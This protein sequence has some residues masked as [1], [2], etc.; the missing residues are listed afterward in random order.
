[1]ENGTLSVWPDASPGGLPS[2]VVVIDDGYARIARD[3]AVARARVSDVLRKAG[4]ALDESGP[5]R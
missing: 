2:T 3:G 5:N 1:V 4:L